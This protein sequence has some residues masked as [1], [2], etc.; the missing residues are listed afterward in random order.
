MRSLSNAALLGL[1]LSLA[2][3]AGAACEYPPVVKTPDG[4]TATQEEMGAA[5][6]AVKAY[7]SSLETYLVCL[8][9]EMAA[10][11][12]EAQTP[13]LKAMHIKKYNAAVAAMES[14]AAAFNEQLRAFKA[15]KK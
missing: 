14:E 4:K 7:M 13:D 2:Q 5:N 10:V 6:Q 15:A 12:P 11:S 8:D 1:T 9:E 3:G